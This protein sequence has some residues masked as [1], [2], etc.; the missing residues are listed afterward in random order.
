MSKEEKRAFYEKLYFHEADTKEKLHARVQGVFAFFALIGTAISYVFKNLTF[1]NAWT[2]YFIHGLLALSVI[3]LLFASLKLR[4]AFWG[5]KYARIATPNEMQAY[6]NQLKE[7]QTNQLKYQK[8]NP[9]TSIDVVNVDEEIADWLNDS[10][11]KAASHNMEVN[12]LR[13]EK[14][15]EA[16]YLMF[17]SLLPLA[18]AML[19]F[20]SFNLDSSAPRNAKPLKTNIVVCNPISL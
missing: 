4:K 11:R 14:I 17:I 15:H 16:I 7:H 13:S 5:N 8:E 20:L 12:S 18:I 19:L 3:L 6:E 1:Y 2:F 9:L 10:F